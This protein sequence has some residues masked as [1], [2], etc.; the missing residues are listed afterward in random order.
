MLCV[1]TSS[2]VDGAGSTKTHKR[3][4][5]S[6]KRVGS[7][8]LPAR[9]LSSRS[10]SSK[11]KRESEQRKVNEVEMNHAGTNAE[12]IHQLH[13]RNSLYYLKYRADVKAA[14][15]SMLCVVYQYYHILRGKM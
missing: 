9:S 3:V 11:R 7:L 6:S 15:K 8:R 5:C 1:Q 4:L 2:G 14:G 10:L 12:A 13:E